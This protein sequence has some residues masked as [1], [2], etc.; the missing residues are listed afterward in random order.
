MTLGA[1]HDHT[2]RRDTHC[3]QTSRACQSGTV[4]S[5][6]YHSAIPPRGRA[7]LD[8][9]RPERFKQLSTAPSKTLPL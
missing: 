1:A 5:A 6:P 2:Q 4:V 3:E 9:Q 8:R 7:R